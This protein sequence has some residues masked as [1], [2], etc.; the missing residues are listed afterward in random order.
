MSRVME[1]RK[2][3]LVVAAH[4]DDEAI[5][6]GGTIARWVKEDVSVMVSFIAD[7]VG[8]RN[9]GGSPDE[10]ALASRRRAAEQAIKALGVSRK[11]RFG[12]L[13]DNQ[14]DTIPLLTIV[15]QIEMLID[16]YQPDTVIT[17]HSGD[18]NV[19]HQR[20]HQAVVT[21]CRPQPGHCVRR[22]LFFEIAS[23]TEWQTP[24]SSAA[25]FLPNVFINISNTLD[26]KVAALQAYHEEMRTW[27]HAR[28]VE[29]VVH[30]A[31]WHGASVGVPAAEVFVLG[32]EIV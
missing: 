13:P 9:D 10:N 26:Q 30:Y 15:R 2:R 31:R 8:S 16:Q 19:D 3:V 29:A 28:S 5:G 25:A 22:L 14:L 7:G 32:R 6:C 24:G 23:S 21:A 12:D 27:P 18:L 4:P 20:V 1:E 11:P 17:H